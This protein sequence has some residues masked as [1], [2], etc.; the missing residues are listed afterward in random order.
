[1]Y[2]TRQEALHTITNRPE[3]G[4]IVANSGLA[5]SAMQAAQYSNKN[6]CPMVLLPER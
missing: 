3:V 1:M 2:P 6:Q 4:D 5:Y